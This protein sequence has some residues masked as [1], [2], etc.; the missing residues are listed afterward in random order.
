MNK[1]HVAIPTLLA[2]SALHQEL[3]RQGNR[4][5]VSLI[6]ETGEAREVHHFAALIGFGADAINPYLAFATYK[7][8]VLDEKLSMSYEEAVQKYVK[9]ITEGVV[10]VMSKMGISTVQSYRGAQIF[11]AVGISSDVIDRYFTGT[12]SQIDGIDLETIAEEATIRHSLAYSDSID[13]TL[14]SGSDFQWRSNG[15]HHAFNPKSIHML[16][17]ACRQGD[18][19]LFKQYSQLANEE[20]IGFLRNLFAFQ[21][22]QQPLPI[23]EVESVDSIVRR[24][25][26]GAMSFGS[27]SQEAHEALAIAM[28]RLGGKSNSGEGGEDSRRYKIR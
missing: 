5:K 24:F 21:S 1:E 8:A 28:N 17:W 23:E 9:V 4:S 16:Q 10:K 11:E 2:V 6:V 25:K 26:T 20:R 27:I 18:Y 13:E 14:D 15:E 3:I 22:K 7:Q 12:A 19:D